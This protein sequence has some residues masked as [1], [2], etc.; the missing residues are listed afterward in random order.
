MT[1]SLDHAIGTAL[2][3]YSPRPGFAAEL[4]EALRRASAV[5]MYETSAP[6][7]V[8]TRWLLAG[9]LAGVAGAA[10]AAYGVMR[11]QRRGRA[12]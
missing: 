5:H 7:S 1:P 8:R 4:L 12:A 11:L 6:G 2:G 3:S 10:S 9:S